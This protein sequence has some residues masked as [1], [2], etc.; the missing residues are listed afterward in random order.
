MPMA[1]KR[2]L[3]RQRPAQNEWKWNVD[4]S[5]KGKPGAAGIGGVLRNDRGDIVAQFAA[6][7]GVRDSN[8]AEFLAIVFALEQ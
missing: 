4:G 3:E 8:E 6:S 7:I 1:A 2:S 5:S